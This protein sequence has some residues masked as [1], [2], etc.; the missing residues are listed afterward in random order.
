MIKDK[1]NIA[2]IVGVSTIMFAS[3][4]VFA[5][6]QST[7]R[8]QPR[9]EKVEF[10]GKHHKKGSG[11]RGDQ[12]RALFKNAD[13]NKDRSITQEEIDTYRAAQVANAD[14][15]KDGNISLAEF[16]TIW[17]AQTKNKMVRAFQRLDSDA[18]GSITQAEHDER[19][20][21][22]VERMDRNGDGQLN[23]D[24]RRKRGEGRRHKKPNN[25]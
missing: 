22:I 2:I 1:K 5:V 8:Q 17:M 7:D 10:G 18:D 15:D 16:E 23:K 12:M 19:F 11:K 3:T 9:M 21:N 24:D 6:A 4:A 14:A 13:A 20:A 25:G